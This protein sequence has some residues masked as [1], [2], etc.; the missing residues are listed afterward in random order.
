ML[1]VALAPPLHLSTR[2]QLAI[3]NPV[4]A[5]LNRIAAAS[6]GSNNNKKL[7][8]QPNS[9]GPERHSHHPTV[10]PCLQ[11]YTPG[12][13]HTRTLSPIDR[14]FKRHLAT[15]NNNSGFPVIQSPTFDDIKKPSGKDG[16]GPSH[17]FTYTMVGAS[18]VLGAMA[19]KSTVVDFLTSLSAAGAVLALAQI[20]VDLSAIPPGKNVVVKWRGKPI[21]I[22]HR[23]EEEIGEAEA[24]PLAELRD[25]QRD[26]DRVQRPEWLVMLGICTHLGCVPLGESGDF[27]G[28]YCPCQYDIIFPV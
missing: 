18:G 1:H 24:V 19:A 12:L 23:T 21:F 20:E 4:Y 7:R 25:P 3:N 27:G 28:W 13:L 9:N 17:A 14:H 26:A 11:Y 8:F 5:M 6:V 10:I 16:S 15:S 2:N 22:R